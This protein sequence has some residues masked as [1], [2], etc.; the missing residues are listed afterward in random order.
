MCLGFP[1]CQKKSLSSSNDVNKTCRVLLVPSE[2]THGHP[3]SSAGHI[4]RA[5]KSYPVL[6]PRTKGEGF[7]AELRALLEGAKGVSHKHPRGPDPGQ[8]LSRPLSSPPCLLPKHLDPCIVTPKLSCGA[9]PSIP[10]PG[11]HQ[12]NFFSSS[13][14]LPH[15][16]SSPAKN[17]PSPSLIPAANTFQKPGVCTPGRN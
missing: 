16:L 14:L 10:C 9:L 17:P 15:R 1:I 3:W 11:L 12:P 8:G 13:F 6:G 2:L 7:L 4:S 5:P